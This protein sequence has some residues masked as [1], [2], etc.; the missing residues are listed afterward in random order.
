MANNRGKINI[1]RPIN[2]QYN[3]VLDTR[4]SG[5]GIGDRPTY[6][7]VGLIRYETSTDSFI[8]WDGTSWLS[9][10]PPT[11]VYENH[12]DA[13]ATQAFNESLLPNTEYEYEY[14]SSIDR[15]SY[16][17]IGNPN[18]D[19]IKTQFSF[20]SYNLKKTT[21]PFLGTEDTSTNNYTVINIPN[22]GK[23]F[24]TSE[25]DNNT[26][27]GD[28]TQNAIK[29]DPVTR[30]VDWGQW[31]FINSLNSTGS[32]DSSYL[33]TFQIATHEGHTD[34][35]TAINASLLP[36]SEFSTD[37]TIDKFSYKL[38]GNPDLSS[39]TGFSF[40]SY[41]VEKTIE[42][43]NPFPLGPSK[44][45]ISTSTDYTA[46]N[47][48]GNGKLFITSSNDPITF[49]SYNKTIDWSDWTFDNFQREGGIF[50]TSDDRLKHNEKKIDNGLYILEK[51]NPLFYQ[52]TKT[53]LDENYTGDLSGYEWKYEAGIIAQDV[54]KINELKYLVN[55]DQK[56]TDNNGNIIE[57]VYSLNYDDL[58][59][60]NI[61]ATK[62]LHK[63]VNDQQELINSL[64][65]RI[66][67]LENK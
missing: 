49:Y 62:E 13:A 21:I 67:M 65:K 61:A 27:E 9:L 52:K 8:Y 60:Y 20:G 5:E 45:S 56:G 46:I 23:L 17:L 25:G 24:I 31:R 10:I 38:I 51:L 7:A 44:Y 42:Y 2:L 33:E 12:S 41:H 39:I 64:I 32:G 63:K 15:F 34:A 11:I 48:P 19:N 35:W 54:E 58:F 26:S 57:G 6:R 40:G 53:L 14:G 1:V 59:V 43:D 36:R 55:K 66:E 30:T 16:N 50:G 18:T 3:S 29:F 47:I 4:C 37:W 22:N 28:N